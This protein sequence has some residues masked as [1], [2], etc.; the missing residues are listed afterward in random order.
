MEQDEIAQAVGYAVA[1]VDDKITRG[2][3]HANTV[4]KD[5]RVV[6]NKYKL[7]IVGERAEMTHL[8]GDYKPTNKPVDEIYNAVYETMFRGRGPVSI[9][10]D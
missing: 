2:Y 7:A 10:D 6:A 5:T 8:V 9:G 4:D 1:S 3:G